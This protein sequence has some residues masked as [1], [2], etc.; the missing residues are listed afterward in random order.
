MSGT[1]LEKQNKICPDVCC[2]KPSPCMWDERRAGFT[3]KGGKDLAAC[4][5]MGWRRDCLAFMGVL[6]GGMSYLK[7]APWAEKKVRGSFPTPHVLLP[8]RADPGAPEVRP[9]TTASLRR[10]W[11]TVRHCTLAGKA[12]KC[13]PGKGARMCGGWQTASRPPPSGGK[14][15]GVRRLPCF[16]HH[17]DIWIVP[18]R[19]VP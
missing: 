17:K 18:R 9:Q 14:N 16:E 7:E 10:W 19:K 5:W 1:I 15:G 4:L 2:L 6:I 11:L 8:P 12:N 3:H 13:H